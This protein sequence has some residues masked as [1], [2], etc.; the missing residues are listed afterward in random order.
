MKLKLQSGSRRELLQRGQLR[1]G[2][3]QRLLKW[4]HLGLGQGM[5]LNGL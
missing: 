4:L 2:L 3:E 5:L 1:Q